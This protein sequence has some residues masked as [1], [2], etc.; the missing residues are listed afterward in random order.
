[1]PAA[2]P[3]RIAAPRPY[4][5]R[6]RALSTPGVRVQSREVTRWLWAAYRCNPAM[7]VDTARGTASPRAH[8]T[9]SQRSQAVTLARWCT[10]EST[11]AGCTPRNDPARVGRSRADALPRERVRGAEE[12]AGGVECR[13]VGLRSPVAGCRSAPRPVARRRCAQNRRAA[14]WSG[15]DVLR[16]RFPVHLASTALAVTSRS[17]LA[18]SKHAASRL[19]YPYLRARLSGPGCTDVV[20]SA[21]WLPLALSNRLRVAGDT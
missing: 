15:A 7:R 2:R 13:D 4:R 9:P 17:R 6:V 21:L 5:G 19:C 16:E 12:G 14:A 8:S 1:M 3:A 11:R 10:R 18:A 20:E